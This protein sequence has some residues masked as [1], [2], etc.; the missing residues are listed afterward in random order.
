M[1][2]RRCGRL[3]MRM[4]FFSLLLFNGR[5]W[6]PFSPNMGLPLLSFHIPDVTPLFEA[7][8]PS[9]PCTRSEK[10]VRS[11]LRFSRSVACVMLPSL[12]RGTA[13]CFQPA[14]LRFP[15]GGSGFSGSV[16]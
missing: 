10:S 11:F 14:V 2:S 7:K 6:R 4:R 1:L 13:F 12:R 16:I 15:R 5:N 3:A 9:N 8:P